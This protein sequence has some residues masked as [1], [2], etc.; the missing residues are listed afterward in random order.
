MEVTLREKRT[1]VDGW[2]L[3]WKKL[4][5]GGGWHFTAH[6]R[7][8]LPGANSTVRRKT[9]LVRSI[10]SVWFRYDLFKKIVRF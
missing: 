7:A 4:E 10:K 5:S 6:K 8:I 9:I 3:M 1:D 2:L